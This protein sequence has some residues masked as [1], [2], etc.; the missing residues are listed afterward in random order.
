MSK[1][2]G[3]GKFIVGASIGAGLGLLFA[4]KKGSETRRELKR[5]MDELVDKARGIDID[6][7]RDNIESK[8][9]DIKSE[10]ADLDK[11]KV[12]KI[13]KKKA[14]QIQDMAEELVSYA[15]DKGTPVLES[16]AEAVRQ[17]AIDVTKE[18][19]NK[20]EKEEK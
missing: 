9:I 10:L 5:K 4:P 1:K 3:F 12:L 2:G 16:S 18:V 7:V 19:L 15:V 11:E 20:L 8:I 13:A 17:K 6:E 14:K